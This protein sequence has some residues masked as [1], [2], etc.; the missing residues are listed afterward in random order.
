M[1]FSVHHDMH[2]MKQFVHVSNVLQNYFIG[3]ASS[4][5]NSCSRTNS[6]S[7]KLEN[8]ALTVSMI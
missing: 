7:L 3:A 8:D 1:K 6:V 5:D 4:A 2:S